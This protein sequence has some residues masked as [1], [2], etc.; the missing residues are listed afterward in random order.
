VRDVDKGLSRNNICKSLMRTFVQCVSNVSS[1]KSYF[2]TG[3]KSAFMASPQIKK[4]VFAN[5][6]II[7]EAAT[8]IMNGHAD[9]VA[10]HENI[11]WL[12]M[13]ERR[14]RLVHG[15]FGVRYDLVWDTVQNDLPALLEKL[16]P[17][18]ES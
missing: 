8:K 5:L 16:P 7:G 11:P 3:P 6:I 9:F 4:A 10:A 13:R 17:P 15:Y 12:A 1:L 18:S 14:N 2:V